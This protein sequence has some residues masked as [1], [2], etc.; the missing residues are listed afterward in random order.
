MVKSSWGWIKRHP[1]L[2][3]LAAIIIAAGLYFAL[4]PAVPQY[5]Y[6]SE[7]VTTGEVVRTVTASNVPPHRRALPLHAHCMVRR[8]G[9]GRVSG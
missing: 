9:V 2:S 1:I 7:A 4:K 5:E 6:V 8:P 3:T